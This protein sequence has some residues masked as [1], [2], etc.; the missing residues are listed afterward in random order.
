MHHL[1]CFLT[2]LLLIILPVTTQ[3][4][5]VVVVAK[6][7]SMM[8]LTEREI[9]RI[10]LAKTRRLNNGL[11]IQPIELSNA[12]YKARFYQKVTGKTLHQ[13]NSYWTTLIFTGK[14]KPPKNLDKT[15]DLLDEL[16]ANPMAIAYLPDKLIDDRLKVVHIVR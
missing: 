2:A 7:S 9:R 16:A 12:E 11:R 14:G 8:E 5:M 13:L 15:H 6:S 10:F 3:A 4:E 1:K